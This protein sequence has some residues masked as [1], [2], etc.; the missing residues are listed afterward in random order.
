MGFSVP[1]L[2]SA[3]IAIWTAASWVTD[4]PGSDVPSAST[5]IFREEMETELKINTLQGK[6]H[7]LNRRH[8]PSSPIGEIPEKS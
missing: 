6:G 4:S 2:D 8:A 7:V 5:N 1:I 3:F